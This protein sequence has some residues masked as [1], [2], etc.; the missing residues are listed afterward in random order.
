MDRGEKKGV[1]QGR[2]VRRASDIVREA[3][4]IIK[5]RIHEREKE[6]GRSVAP[7]LAFLLGMM[8]ATAL[9]VAIRAILLAYGQAL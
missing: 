3:D 8:S 1:R 9:Q 7:W 4:R 5:E 2:P 6:N